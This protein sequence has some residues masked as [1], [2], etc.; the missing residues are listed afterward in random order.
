MWLRLGPSQER[1]TL[2]AARTLTV[3]WLAFLLA[4]QLVVLRGDLVELGDVRPVLDVVSPAPTRTLLLGKGT[5]I[6][7]PSANQVATRVH[8]PAHTSDGFLVGLPCYG[9]L[10]LS[11][12]VREDV[13][14]SFYVA[15]PF[16]V[17]DASDQEES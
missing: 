10:A 3:E 6:D 8:L 9:R 12:V 1:V 11:Y 5:A 17:R 15:G 7:T 13:V 2:D 14:T 16:R 4:A